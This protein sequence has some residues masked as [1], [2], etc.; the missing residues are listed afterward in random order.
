MDDVKGFL[1]KNRIDFKL[2]EHPP[3]YTCEE[4]E[5]Y[6]KDLRGSH[7]KNLFLKDSKSKRFFLVVMRADKKLNMDNLSEKLGEK[8]K[9]A[10]EQDLMMLLG[11]SPGSVSFFGLLNDYGKKVEL[12]IEKDV[13]EADFVSFHPNINTETLEFD[14]Q[15]FHKLVEMFGNKCHVFEL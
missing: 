14:K 8:I 4:A 5:K 10:N 12:V 9:F 15:G 11:L 6:T 1:N 2:Y 3:V 13:W 7:L